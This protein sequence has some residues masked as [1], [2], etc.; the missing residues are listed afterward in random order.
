M[1]NSA[2]ENS[3][4]T[5][6]I[7]HIRLTTTLATMILALIMSLYA[8]K[9]LAETSNTETK[10]QS[11]EELSLTNHNNLKDYLLIQEIVQSMSP[12]ADSSTRDLALEVKLQAEKIKNLEKEVSELRKPDD[13]NVATLLLSAVSVIITVLGVLIAILAILGYRN[14]K[15]E[16]IKDAR[17]T[18]KETVK[19]VAKE[20]IPRATEENIIKLIEEN[21]FDRLIQNAVENI[22][23]RDTSM[24]DEVADEERSN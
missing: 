22:V 8:I 19:I 2:Q 21:R 9:T 3:T 20:E 18:A 1:P 16:A 13:N 14:I 24:P 23:Y 4:P 5:L 7:R 6:N 10:E 17:K 15:N 11:Q 12:K